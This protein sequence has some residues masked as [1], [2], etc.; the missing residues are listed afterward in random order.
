MPATRIFTPRMPRA[1]Y[2]CTRA[3][4]SSGAMNGHSPPEP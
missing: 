3:T 4:A 2:S 1:M